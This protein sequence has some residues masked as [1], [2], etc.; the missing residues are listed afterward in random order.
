MIIYQKHNYYTSQK[1]KVKDNN[2]ENMERIFCPLFVLLTHIDNVYP[3]I[4]YYLSH[5]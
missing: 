2:E 4:D 3:F 1:Y 5:I